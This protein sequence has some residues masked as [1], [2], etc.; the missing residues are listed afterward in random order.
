MKK[1][2]KQ[3]KKNDLIDNQESAKINEASKKLRLTARD[4]IIPRDDEDELPL[5]ETLIGMEHDNLEPE[6]RPEFNKGWNEDEEFF[7]KRS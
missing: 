6:L 2:A 5:E 4:E 1:S 3:P 7:P